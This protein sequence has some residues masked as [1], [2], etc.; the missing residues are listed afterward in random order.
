MQVAHVTLHVGLGTFLP[1]ETATLEEHPMHTEQYAVP[2][3]TVAALRTQRVAGGTQGGRIVVVGTT[4]TRT[5]EAAAPQILNLDHPPTDLRGCTNLLISPGFP[6]QLTD[7]LITNFHLP[8]ST[9]LALVG[10]LTGLDHL[11]A[12]YA[13]AIEK[14]YRFYSYGDAMIVL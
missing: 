2:A 3:T 11:K 4:A 12:L 13:E 14:G 7:A 1:V 6:F 9:L 8:R 5:L 10:A